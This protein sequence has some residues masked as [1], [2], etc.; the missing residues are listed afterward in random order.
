MIP[1]RLSKSWNLCLIL[2]YSDAFLY[3]ITVV[4]YCLCSCRPRKARY[5]QA[6]FIMMYYAPRIKRNLN[7]DNSGLAWYPNR[8]YNLSRPAPHGETLCTRGVSLAY[9]FFP[10]VRLGRTSFPVLLVDSAIFLRPRRRDTR[11]LMFWHKHGPRR[12]KSKLYRQHA[13]TMHAFCNAAASAKDAVSVF[14][15]WRRSMRLTI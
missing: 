3:R 10:V 4:Y 11:F 15:A 13:N 7:K 9:F 12:W 14:M 5:S 2:K 8:L 6:P 1:Q